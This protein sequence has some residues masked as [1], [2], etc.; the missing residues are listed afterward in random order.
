MR[1]SIQLNWPGRACR[2]ATAVITVVSAAAT[3]TV[4]AAE[5]LRVPQPPLPPGAER[6]AMPPLP[7]SPVDNFRYWLSFSPKQREPLL[8]TLPEAER[9]ALLEK[10]AFYDSLPADVRNLRLRETQL[11][12]QLLSLMKLPPA[13]RKERIA[14]LSAD[15]RAVVDERLRQWD[16]LPADKQKTF[17]E[18]EQVVGLYLELQETA[19]QERGK[20][21]SNLPPEVRFPL[22]QRLQK[23]NTLPAAQRQ[24]L[25]DRFTVLFRSEESAQKKIVKG[26]P[27]D[28]RK[29]VEKLMEQ[30]EGMPPNDRKKCTA[31]LNKFLKMSPDEQRQFL[32]NATRWQKMSEKEHNA[33]RQVVNKVPQLPPLPPGMEPPALIAGTNSVV[34]LNAP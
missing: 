6:L 14:Q 26:L 21:L 34:P 33:W 15:N 8:A 5:N 19:P 30:L 9:K 31:A 18:N 2:S 24:E 28:V 25:S 20:V 3:M 23:W 1:I 16:A 4:V 13:E 12:W 32:Q 7:Q 17:L 27:D 10:L 22:E 29:P 11:H